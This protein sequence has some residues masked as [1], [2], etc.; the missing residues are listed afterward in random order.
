MKQLRIEVF[1]CLCLLVLSFSA[2]AEDMER[3]R[4]LKDLQEIEKIGEIINEQT[5][6]KLD[7]RLEAMRESA[8][9]Y[10]ARGGLAMRTFEIRQELESRAAYMDKVFNFNQLLIP[11]PSGLLI[12]PPIISEAIDAMIIESDGRVAAVADRIYNISANAKIVTNG[13]HWREYL[14]RDWGEVKD[15]PD[16]LRPEN[17]KERK[18]WRELVQKGWEFGIEQADEIFQDDLNRLISDFSG[19]VRYRK[20]LAQ[21]MVSAPF[22]LQVDRGITGGGDVMRVGDRAIQITGMPELVTGHKQ[23]QPASR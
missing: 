2:K 19:M 21:N 14:E 17:D 3:P 11:A 4:P 22:A 16:I 1:A 18:Q 6:M 15:P 20:L 9:S 10:G 7:I 13:R 8:L 12:E 5:G 23:W